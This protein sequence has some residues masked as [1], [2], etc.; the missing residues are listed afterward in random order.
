VVDRHWVC[1]TIRKS[2]ESIIIYA[3]IGT[4]F[5]STGRRG[6]IEQSRCLSTIIFTNLCTVSIIYNSNRTFLLRPG[7]GQLLTRLPYPQIPACD[8]GPQEGA[9]ETGFCSSLWVGH[10][11]REL[12]KADFSQLLHGCSPQVC[13]LHHH[14]ATKK[15][16]QLL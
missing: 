6:A 15:R 3:S 13:I 7:S 4:Y 14:R 11:L 1:I 8:A 2:L 9:Q 12:Y 16:A 10:H 5:I